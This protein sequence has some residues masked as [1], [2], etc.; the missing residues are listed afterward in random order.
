MDF[1]DRQEQARRNT[2]LLVVYFAAGV[3]LLIAAVYLAALLIFA[4]VNARHHE[5]YSDDQPRAVLW[6]PRILFGAAVGTLAVIALGSLFKI[7]E[8]ARGGSVVATNLGG[9]L[10]NL[11]TTDPD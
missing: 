7:S 3:T 5:S 8:L 4:G 9:Q 1:F 6:N 10:V 2:K 11:S